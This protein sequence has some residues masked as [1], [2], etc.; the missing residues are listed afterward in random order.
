M[1]YTVG[2]EN[3]LFGVQR[4]K[5]LGWL[6]LLL[7]TS[8]AQAAKLE[9]QGVRLWAAPDNT[10]VV[11]DVSGP[12]AHR[13]FTLKAPDRLVIDLDNARMSDKARKSLTSAGM[14]TGL[15]SGQRNKENLRV[16]LDLSRPVKPKSFVL[17]PNDQYGHRLV[18]DLYDSA[19]STRT[20]PRTE[21]KS[22]E[23]STLRDVVVAID[24][25]HGG[26][27][28][29][30]RG[31]HGA[32]EKDVVLAIARKLAA[33]VNREP[34]M[35]AVL[36]RSGDYYVGL[37]KRMEIARK[38]RADLFMSIHAD[39]FSDRRVQG[40]SVFVLSR[41]GASSEMARWL[42]ARENAA[43]LVGGVSLDDK[44]DLLA[45]VLLDLAQAAT[46]EASIQ[47]AEKVFY[48]MK[49]IGN[50]HK[51]T[52]QHAGFMV[53]K[54][55]DIPSL[56]VET[57]FISNPAE[58]SR[59]KSSRHQQAVAEALFK[60]ITGYF[61]EHAPPGTRIARTQSR[62]HVIRNGDTLSQ[63]ARRYGISMG[64]LRTANNLRSDRL[65]VGKVL[66]IPLQG[67]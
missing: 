24:A 34:G 63:L 27:D 67:S 61:A 60:G 55:P 48:H 17:K 44:D 41:R 35:R 43:D 58:E 23:S 16:V 62:Q 56:L 33:L 42:A 26:E 28:P 46:L 11:F 64:D 19:T 21:S 38:H 57:A 54:S 47:V 39:A 12:A 52:V 2:C 1:L 32:R 50:V 31:K 29:G 66:K 14:V 15:R 40:S 45:E 10:R 9:I 18:V 4:V 22:I 53:L 51:K 36:V 3:N 37:R 25:G 5:R 49:K 59:L 8:F 65:M 30:A 13:L 6:L 7:A 20:A